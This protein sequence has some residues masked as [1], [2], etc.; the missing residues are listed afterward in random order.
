M[1]SRGFKVHALHSHQHVKQ[2]S[3]F[4]PIQANIMEVGPGSLGSAS[5][6]SISY[7]VLKKKKVNGS[8]FVNRIFPPIVRY[9]HFLNI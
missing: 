5:M 8:G 4:T 6:D 9:L 2:D 7:T 3:P 1:F